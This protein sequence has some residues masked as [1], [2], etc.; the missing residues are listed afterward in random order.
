MQTGARSPEELEMLLEDTLVLHD[1]ASLAGLFDERA[2]LSF[3][4]NRP[5]RGG[6]LVAGFTAAN[7]SGENGYLA[8][9][10]LVV[11]AGDTAL[12]LTGHGANVLRRGAD[13]T[14]RYQILHLESTTRQERKEA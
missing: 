3:A 11:Q 6:V 5:L 13:G 14:W 1:T 9:P 8:D 12:V 4:G 10:R 2:V 7:F